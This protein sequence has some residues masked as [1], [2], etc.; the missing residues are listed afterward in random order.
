MTVE[1]NNF[2]SLLRTVEALS[3]LGPELTAEREFSETARL[4]LSA[5]MEA[6]GATEGALFIFNEKP[7]MLT[8]VAAQGFA[9]LPEPA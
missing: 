9:M 8:S 6:A 1:T 3:E 7:T 4:M 5:V 2:R